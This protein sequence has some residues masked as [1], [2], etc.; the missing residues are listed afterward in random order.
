M[1][2][3]SQKSVVGKALLLF[4]EKQQQRKGILPVKLH[5]LPQNLDKTNRPP[6]PQQSLTPGSNHGG[7]GI[8]KFIRR[9]YEKV[10]RFGIIRKKPLCWRNF[11]HHEYC[12]S[13]S[14]R[15]IREETEFYGLK[16]YCSSK[17]TTKMP[18]Q[19]HYVHHHHQQGYFYGKRSA[20][21]KNSR[22]IQYTTQRMGI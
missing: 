10:R 13:S 14:I 4:R 11:E 1:P 20:H 22:Y 17:T 19:H 2:L 3:K 15:V 8:K 5:I 16:Y 9:S 18:Q 6:Y 12:S 7:I 21:N